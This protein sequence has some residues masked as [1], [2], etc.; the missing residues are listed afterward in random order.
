QKLLLKIIEQLCVRKFGKDII[1]SAWFK[2]IKASSLRQVNFSWPG[3][4]KDILQL[5]R[6]FAC[7]KPV[8]REPLRLG[9][10]D[11]NRQC[12]D[13]LCLGPKYNLDLGSNPVN[14]S[15]DFRDVAYHVEPSVR[16]KFIDSAV[17]SIKHFSIRGRFSKKTISAVAK[18]LK[19]QSAKVLEADKDC[20]FIVCDEQEYGTRCHDAMNKNFDEKDNLFIRTARANFLKV[21][22]GMPHEEVEQLKKMV[23]RNTNSALHVFFSVK[24][25]KDGFPFRAIVSEKGTY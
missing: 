25:H 16:D 14:V 2:Q 20:Q 18:H 19:N 8:L 5:P 10:V 6:F 4:L 7:P 21:L 12:V 9:S 24:T 15:A 3:L 1:N 13:V 17:E 22:K 23:S 11:L